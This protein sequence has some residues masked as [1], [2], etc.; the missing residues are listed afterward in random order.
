MYIYLCC[1]FL[2]KRGEMEDYKKQAQQYVQELLTKVEQL[3]GRDV[4]EK[5]KQN[6]KDAGKQQ[7]T[8]QNLVRELT[9]NYA[10]ELMERWEEILR[11]TTEQVCVCL[12]WQA[13]HTIPH[14][15]RT[16]YARIR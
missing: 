5:V 12:M 7:A 16:P 6:I 14:F 11:K 4:K 3:D 10:P 8:V 15:R 2:L 13:I 9:T 1:P